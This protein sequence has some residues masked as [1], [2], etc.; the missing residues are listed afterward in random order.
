VK[1]VTSASKLADY[2][3]VVEEDDDDKKVWAT[4]TCVL[5]KSFYH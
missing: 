5:G 2:N 1:Q 3:G 4:Q